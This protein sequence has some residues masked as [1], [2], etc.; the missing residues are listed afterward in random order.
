MSLAREGAEMK[1]EELLLTDE[2]MIN[3]IWTL[4]EDLRKTCVINPNQKQRFEAIAKAQLDKFIR[5]GGVIMGERKK[6][7]AGWYRVEEIA[8]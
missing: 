6:G 5:L 7:H 1:R 4:G 8:P 3:S 2:E